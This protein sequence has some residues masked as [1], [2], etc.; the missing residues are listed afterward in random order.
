VLVSC[1]RFYKGIAQGTVAQFGTWSVDEANK[2]LTRRPDS[3]FTRV[4][5]G[6]DA[7]AS[8][9]LTGDELKLTG[10]DGGS[11]MWKNRIVRFLRHT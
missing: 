6:N 7:K 4:N 8:I 3:T 9:S 11:T 1:W 5:E 10:A 2:T